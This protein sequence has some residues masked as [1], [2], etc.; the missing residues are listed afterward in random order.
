[1][2]NVMI[3]IFA[4]LL[5]LI[6]INAKI[7]EKETLLEEGDVVYLKLAPVDPR[8][9]MQG[10]YMALRFHAGNRIRSAIR[11]KQPSD[12][13]HRSL[14]SQDG[15]VTV[16]LDKKSIGTFARLTN[17]QPLTKNEHLIKFRIRNGRVKFATNAYFF[18]EGTAKDYEQARYGEFRVAPDGDLLLKSL[19]DKDLKLMGPSKEG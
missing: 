1:M 12:K 3:V 17:Q 9:L 13:G 7:L 2:R 10:D 16:K 6:L 5:I 4:G 15:T 18:Q 8:S 14:E 19:R 11:K